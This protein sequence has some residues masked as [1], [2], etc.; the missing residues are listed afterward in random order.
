MAGC[1]SPLK[2]NFENYRDGFDGTYDLIGFTIE[3]KLP[4][5]WVVEAIDYKRMQLQL[6]QTKTHARISIGP[7]ILYGSS[8][9]NSRDF[10]LLEHAK[11]LANRQAH[12]VGERER[13]LAVTIRDNAHE[14]NAR[15]WAQF[16]LPYR[17]TTEEEEKTFDAVYSVTFFLS[18]TKEMYVYAMLIEE[19]NASE[20][21]WEMLNNLVNN[22]TWK[23]TYDEKV[24]HRVIVT[25]LFEELDE[26]LAKAQMGK[27]TPHLLEIKER[28]K[29][30]LAAEESDYLPA[31]KKWYYIG[32]LEQINAKGE[33][34]GE[35]FDHDLVRH[36]FEESI[37][38]RPHYL[39]S[40]FAYYE[41]LLFEKKYEEAIAILE[42]VETVIPYNARPRY[43]MAKLYERLEDNY[44][45]RKKYEEALTFLVKEN[46]KYQEITDT[47][48][49]LA[50]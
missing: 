21:L 41:L 13:E 29:R 27:P 15:Q 31:Y 45:A 10:T 8:D 25:V 11:L 18:P 17:S 20:D 5:E 35:G 39:A 34:F 33:R 32:L 7:F 43:E 50:P 38:L 24:E 49:R 9:E 42:K 48:K 44:N 2:Y 3:K 23:K 16:Y 14:E 37:R 30:L 47:L 40:L 26:A 1:A 6:R 12:R 19:E 22:V 4:E 46:P 28:I 36:A